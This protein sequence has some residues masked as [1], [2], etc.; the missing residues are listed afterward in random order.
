MYLKEKS[1]KDNKSR[2]KEKYI[3]LDKERHFIQNIRSNFLNWKINI[4]AIELIEV[5]QNR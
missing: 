3:I 5:I 2:Y 4:H 1:Q